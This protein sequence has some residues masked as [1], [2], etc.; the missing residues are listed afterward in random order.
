[1]QAEMLGI[2][3]STYDAVF[4]H[5]VSRNLA[6]AGRACPAGSLA[7]E[8]QEHNDNLKFTRNGQTLTVHPPRR[9]DFSDIQELMRIRHFLEGSGAP[10]QEAVA[11]GNAPA[12]RDRSSRGAHF[13]VGAAWVGAAEHHCPTIRRD[14]TGI[15]ATSRR[16]PMAS[17]SRKTKSFYQAIAGTLS[18][19]EKILILG[20]GTGASSA[21]DQ[22]VTCLSN[23]IRSLPAALP[24]RSWLTNNTCP[25]IS[26]WPRRGRSTPGMLR[27]VYLTWG[28][29]FTT[30][31]ARRHGAEK[32]ERGFAEK[33]RKIRTS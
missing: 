6:V 25:T 26:C 16:M 19:A 5:P 13:Q 11:R 33:Q 18:G 32:F 31:Q 20:S 2:H 8:T 7:D 10:S 22:L 12:G 4:Q 24:A 1:M 14:R 27:P 28:G 15:F 30:E 17:A 23:P 3:K 9:K 21:M 29:R